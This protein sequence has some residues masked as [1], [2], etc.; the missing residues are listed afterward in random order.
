VTAALIIGVL[1]ALAVSALAVFTVRTERGRSVARW[2]AKACYRVIVGAPV[3]IDP[4]RGWKG[5][6]HGDQAELRVMH[7]GDCSLRAMDTSHDFYAPVG[8]PKVIA[9]RLLDQ[10]FGMEFG[11]YF[12][13][14]YE[15]LPEIERLRKVTKLSDAPDLILVHTGATY[16]RRVILK[17]TERVNQVR[18]EVGRRL[19]RRI[20]SAHRFLVRPFVRRLGRHWQP[21]QGTA[22]LES[23]IDELQKAWPKATVALVAPFPLEWAYPTSADIHAQVIADARELAERRGLPFFEFDNV[24]VEDNLYCA[25]GYNLNA[26]GAELVGNVLANW[27]L[28]TILEPVGT[29]APAHSDDAHWRRHSAWQGGIRTSS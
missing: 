2:W 4:V 22:K 20:F 27:V 23:F 10:R 21:Y 6:A 13:I 9:E 16:Q 17:S 19:G 29:P 28:D 1:G 26:R 8:Y 24:L 5:T 3:T 15:D 25:N 12:T 18:L 14:V 7:V 11:H